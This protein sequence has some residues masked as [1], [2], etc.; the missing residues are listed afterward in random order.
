MLGLQ[1]RSSLSLAE[2][3]SELS[4][5]SRNG[6]NRTNPHD[7]GGMKRWMG[8]DENDMFLLFLP[9]ILE[10]LRAASS[11]VVWFGSQVVP[12]YVSQRFLTPG[13]CGGT[14][15]ATW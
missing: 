2:I 6:K 3:S 13:A 1:A 11:H 9:F 15:H 10:M 14:S 4:G 7:D 5:T 12:Q 8:D